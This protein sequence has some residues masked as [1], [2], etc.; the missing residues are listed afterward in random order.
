MNIS[1]ILSQS[2][3]YNTTQRTSGIHIRERQQFKFI[4]I[5]QEKP[6]HTTCAHSE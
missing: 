1:I 6:N 4:Y 2:N 3:N 5:L